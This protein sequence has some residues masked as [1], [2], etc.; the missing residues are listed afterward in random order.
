MACEQVLASGIAPSLIGYE[1]EVGS[2]EG[3]APRL[4]RSEMRSQM[5]FID[6]VQVK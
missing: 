3:M 2:V 1:D 4:C 5:I 6:F